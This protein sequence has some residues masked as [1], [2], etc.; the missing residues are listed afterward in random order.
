MYPDVVG[1]E[2]LEPS[3]LL[4]PADFKSAA[5]TIPP[6]AHPIVV[7]GPAKCEAFCGVKR[8]HCRRLDAS[9]A[10]NLWKPKYKAKAGG[11]YRN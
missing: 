2:G 1:E 7:W 11:A 6:L 5:Y 10:S 4:R 8:K 3:R 9:Y